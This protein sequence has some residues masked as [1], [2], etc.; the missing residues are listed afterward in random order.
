MRLAHRVAE[1]RGFTL[2]ELLVALVISGIL[3]AIILQLLQGQTRFTRVQSAREE[4]QQNARAVV[5]LL[6]GELRGVPGG[7]AL[8]QATADSVTA[9]VPRVW[10]VVCTTPATSSRLQVVLASDGADLTPTDS[11]GL[12]VELRG[13]GTPQ[14]SNDVRVTSVGAPIST[15]AG[16]ALPAGAVMREIDFA[17]SLAPSPMPN[18]TAGDPVYVYDPVTYRVGHSDGVEGLWVQ[19]RSD[20]SGSQPF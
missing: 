18:P 15:C 17:G 3:A 13:G 20:G 1:R 11:T 12:V 16:E 8:V 9:R 10:G 14:W 4:V 7:D 5:E 6:A 2:V 19:R